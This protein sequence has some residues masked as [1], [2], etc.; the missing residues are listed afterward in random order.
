M[1]A[2]TA[3]RRIVDALRH[4]DADLVMPLT[5]A[6]ATKLHGAFPGGVTEVVG[7]I[8]RLLPGPGGIGSAMRRGADS[9]SAVSPS[10]LTTLNNRA[11]VA[12]NELGT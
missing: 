4:G 10:V 9:E 11:A 5:A 2:T 8:D 12:N 6:L 1:S 3:A 7:L